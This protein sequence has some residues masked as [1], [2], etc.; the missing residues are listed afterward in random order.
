MPDPRDHP[1]AIEARLAALG[2]TM[3]T[4]PPDRAFLGAVRRRGHTRT[5]T[6]L[7]AGLALAAT[8]TLAVV[9]ARSNPA[10]PGVPEPR[11]VQASLARHA[12]S[13]ASLR[14]TDPDEVDRHT[15]PPSLPARPAGRASP[16]AM[17]SELVG[18]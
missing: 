2:R 11:L 6:R 3:P 5:L 9:L 1:P 16:G 12:S 13:F 18:G 7:G 10:L 15:Q 8:I 4:P 17:M 14:G